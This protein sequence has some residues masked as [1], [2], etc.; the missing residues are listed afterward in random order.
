MDKILKAKTK[1]K[2]IGILLT[3][4]FVGCLWVSSLKK[5]SEQQAVSTL[6]HNSRI[7]GRN[8]SEADRILRNY[9]YG[10]TRINTSIGESEF[11]DGEYA[12]YVGQPKWRLVPFGLKRVVIRASVKNG[13]VGH[14]TANWESDLI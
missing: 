9:G 12:F 14:C 3:S 10:L 6:I 2:L 4:I 11:G 13:K 8:I 7:E 5:M 1:W